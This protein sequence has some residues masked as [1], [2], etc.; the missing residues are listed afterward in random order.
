MTRFFYEQ[1]ADLSA[2]DGQSLAIVGYGNQGRPWALNLRDSGLDPL[3]CVRNDD[4]RAVAKA[5]GFAV[6][7]VADADSADVV[8]ILVPD[9][10]IPTLGLAR[11]E[12]RLTIVA[13]G[14]SYAFKRFDPAGDQ[15]MIAPRMLGPEVRSAALAAR[16]AAAAE[17]K[18]AAA[19]PAA[20]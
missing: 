16:Q 11:G 13:S 20:V 14:Y 8:C 12:G 3:V 1:D 18:E 7:E 2:L 4:S 9:D 6:G 10:A 17:E 5:D 19:E 15:A